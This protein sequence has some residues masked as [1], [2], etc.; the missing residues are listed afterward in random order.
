MKNIYLF[1]CM[2][3]CTPLGAQGRQ[4]IKLTESWKFSK[5]DLSEDEKI[6]C[7]DTQWERISIPHDWAIYGPFDRKYDLQEVA[8]MQNGE[9]V[10]TVKQVG[11]VDF[12]TLV[13]VG[14]EPVSM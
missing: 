7:D 10:P 9:K 1:L 6:N 11:R 14:T 3:I 2:L 12:L 13:L 8:I 5:G 4:E